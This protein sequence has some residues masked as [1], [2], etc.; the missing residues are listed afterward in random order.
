[1]IIGHE[2]TYYLVNKDNQYS[3]AEDE[4][5]LFYCGT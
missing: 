3:I 5:S 1:M 4:G 2:N